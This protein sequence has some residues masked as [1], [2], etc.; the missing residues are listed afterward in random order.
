M[1]AAQRSSSTVDRSRVA[2][3]VMAAGKGTRLRSSTAKVLHDV[4]GRS[5]LHHVLAAL[6]PL[7]LGQ[8]VV[9]VGHQAETVAAHADEYGLAGLTTVVQEPQ[10][11]TAH[12]VQ[13]G[14]TAALLS[15][16]V[17]DPSGYGRVLRGDDGFVVGIVEDRDASDEQRAVREINAG[18]YA[19]D[20]EGLDER[21]AAIGSDNDQGE[22]YVT[23]VVAHLV[24][25]G[26]EVRAVRVEPSA[27]AGVN[28]QAQLA[29]AAAILRRRH[30]D[31]LLASGVRVLDPAAT[32]VDVTVDVEPE[33]TILPGC[34]LTGAS[35]V[36]TGAVVGPHTTL[37][38]TEVGA[39]AHVRQSWCDTAAIGPG[40]LV[41]PFAHVRPGTELGEGGKIGAFAEVKNSTVGAGSKIPHLAYVG[42]A[43]LGEG[44]NFACGSVTVNYDGRDKHHTVVGDGA[45]V[46]CDSMLVAPVRIGA[47]AYVAA[48]STITQ[49]VPDDALAV[50]RARQVVKED[51]A[52][53][54]READ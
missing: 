6:E 50:A 37:H 11:G 9:V 53:R 49:D 23:T 20:R 2:A 33:A 36:A 4:A 29:D 7:G 45:F 5:L 31:G 22:R 39:H 3:V 25:E 13:V 43:S 51:W 42:D 14:L 16:V 54:R 10:H 35:L 34:L 48:G 12:A 32:W 8:V 17:D 18:M 46:G 47:G 26:V 44:V 15:A 21:M 28:D 38:D 19:F 40:A 1:A 30:L 41:G 24:A 52:A 27:V